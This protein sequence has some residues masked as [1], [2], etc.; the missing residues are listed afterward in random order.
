MDVKRYSGYFQAEC[1]VAAEDVDR[2]W[3]PHTPG[4]RYTAVDSDRSSQYD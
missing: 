1:E 4:E 2:W 3:L